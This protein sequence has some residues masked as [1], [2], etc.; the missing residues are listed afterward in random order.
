[1][2]FHF[3]LERAHW[4]E[5]IGNLLHFSGW[6]LA[7]ENAPLQAVR[8]NRTGEPIRGYYGL[9]RPDVAQAFP[10]LPDAAFSGFSFLCDVSPAEFPLAIEV[11]DEAQQWH[12]VH[13]VQATDL[14]R[15]PAMALTDAERDGCRAVATPSPAPGTKPVLFIS[16]DFAAAGAQFLL[17]RLLQWLQRQGPLSAE[18]LVAV[19]RSAALHA[20]EAER[21][22][23]EG[24]ARIG[25][26]H[27]LSDVTGTPENLALIRHEHYRL[28]YANT[29]TLG[30]L[31]PALRPFTAPVISHVHELGFWLKHKTGLP[32]VARQ[33]ANTDRFI[34]CSR[35][36]RDCLVGVA[37]VPDEKIEIIH[38]C[39]SLKHAEQTCRL[40]TRDSVRNELNI[41]AGAFV[42]V[43]CGTFDWRKGAELFIPICVA[44]QRALGGRDFRAFWIGDYGA[45]LVRDQFNHEVEA[46]GLAGKVFLTGPQREPLRWML[47]ADCFALPSRED[48]FPIVMVEAG[49]MGLPVVGF[50]GS[51]GVEEFVGSDAGMIVPYN[52]VQAF[53]SALAAMAANPTD[54]RRRGEAARARARSE[55]DEDVSFARIARWLQD[56]ARP[57]S[58]IPFS[59]AGRDGATEASPSA[60]PLTGL[61]VTVKESD[62]I[63][64][65]TAHLRILIASTPK[66]GNVW[67]K[68]LLA[69]AYKLPIVD[70]P[71]TATGPE[72][73]A[74]GDRWICHQHL[75][76][77]ESLR[78][79]LAEL[80]V[81]VITSIRHPADV[82][83]SYFHFVKVMV[84]Q[85]LLTKT[86]PETVMVDDGDI[87]GQHTLSYVRGAFSNLLLYS[88]AWLPFRP[89]V[90]RYEDLITNPVGTMG[91]VT[92][93]LVRVGQ[94]RLEMAV[95]LCEL[96]VLRQRFPAMAYHFRRGESRAVGTAEHLP[97]E[98]LQA[99]AS[100]PPYPEI[101]LRLGYSYG[102]TKRVPRF[103]YSRIN[104]FR[105]HA[106]FTNGVPLHWKLVRIYLMLPP[107]LR[108]RWPHPHDA[109]G[110]DSYFQH[111]LRPIDQATPVITELADY[112]YH[113]RADIGQC[114]PDYLG[115]DRWKF[116][117]WF[118][119]TGTVE[120]GL[121]QVFTEP[122]ISS[123]LQ[124]A[125]PPA[126]PIGSAP[127]SRNPFN[128]GK[129]SP[130]RT[131]PTEPVPAR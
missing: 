68:Y 1:M 101:N 12:R 23:L 7:K 54:R 123:I 96:D 39:S 69:T 127:A 37:G 67:L 109:A 78:Q 30:W 46:S 110:A 77:T 15:R 61:P 42:V 9:R 62:H 88:I 26:V 116:V 119:Y 21:R 91:R 122:I 93:V 71:M 124:I 55:F 129:T 128:P 16:H 60:S 105:G 5:P 44:L 45:P 17:L 117:N 32:A 104:P 25:R 34:A 89:I 81:H 22:L 48:P 20:S 8:L 14:T 56:P 40:H 75:M 24:F 4:I 50:Q 102:E 27:F 63:V 73:E 59:G 98:I 80:D 97:D 2:E 65:D 92:D 126:S 53:A 72:F 47:A 6:L 82:L 84:A 125:P 87:P 79:A 13:T 94:Q 86:N 51:G 31:L 49:V 10:S 33:A 38:T 118:I 113:E 64:A 95:A 76:P 18:I 43:A 19:P 74:L 103:D 58:Q 3:N 112:I 108:R 115:Q 36:V 130:G 66:T 114:F 28:I 107:A 41:P 90:V 11:Q 85:N 100:S 83:L 131:T 120:Y 70:V 52:D 99:L 57:S 111:L 106:T 35:A 29:A 121:S